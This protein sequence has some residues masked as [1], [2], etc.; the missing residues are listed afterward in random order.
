MFRRARLDGGLHNFSSHS[1]DQ[2]SITWLPAE[3]EIGKY[4]E[5]ILPNLVFWS[6]Q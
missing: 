5:E 3:D 2:I 6:T 4:R 1:F